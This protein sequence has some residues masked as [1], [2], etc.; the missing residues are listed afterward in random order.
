MR[1]KHPGGSFEVHPLVDARHDHRLA[2]RLRAQLA[3]FVV[4]REVRL[5]L[6]KILNFVVSTL[7]AEFGESPCCWL[8]SFYLVHL[9]VDD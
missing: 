1:N 2:P 5:F 8:E 6:L 9:V 4:T 3:Q 7:L